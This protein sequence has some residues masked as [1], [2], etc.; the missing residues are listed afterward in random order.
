VIAG[1]RYGRIFWIGAAGALVLAA[2]IGISALLSSDFSETDGQILLTLLALVVATGAATAGLAVS[3][4]GHT[5]IGPS[6]VALSL[7]AFVVIVLSTW[8]GFDSE[9]LAKLAATAAFALIGAVLCTT[10]LVLHRGIHTWVVVVTWAALVLAFVLSTGALWGED[11]DT[12]KAAASMWI[13][14]LVGWLLL[15]VLQ[16][17][18]AAGAPAAGG[19][20]LATLGDVELVATTAGGVDPQLLPGERV[21]LRRR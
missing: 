16:R 5:A 3:E 20:V 21:L 15:P 2:L 12:W 14:G 6:A 4:R 13:V 18:T 11:G 8:N 10:Q 7:V 17:F 9:T 1:V 19:R